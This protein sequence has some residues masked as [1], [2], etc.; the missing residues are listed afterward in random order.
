MK[1]WVQSL[2]L[3]SLVFPFLAWGQDA[4]ENYYAERVNLEGVLIYRTQHVSPWAYSKVQSIAKN[5]LASLKD[6]SVK[7]RLAKHRLVVLNHQDKPSEMPFLEIVGPDFLRQVDTLYR[8]FSTGVLT[9]VTEEMMCK[10]GV[11][12]RG[13]ADTAWRKFDQVVH[14]WAHTIEGAHGLY[15]RTNQ[16]AK[17]SNFD[18]FW[19]NNPRELFAMSV[20]TWFHQNYSYMDGKLN[21]RADLKKKHPVMYNYLKEIFDE[22][23]TWIPECQ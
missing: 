21:S 9:V 17:D 16:V 11:A 22:N 15:D 8:G 1:G 5:M 7:D 10:K 12:S 6:K 18:S 23:G 19:K 14:E 2:V 13:N 3:C 4:R 20:Q